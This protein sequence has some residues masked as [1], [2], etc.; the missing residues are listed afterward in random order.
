MEY[1][2]N[3]KS[4]LYDC[5]YELLTK[6]PILQRSEGNIVFVVYSF[7]GSNPKSANY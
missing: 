2:K 1:V 7:E 6:W 4:F 3:T 5:L